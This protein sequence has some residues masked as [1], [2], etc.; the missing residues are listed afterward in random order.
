MRKSNTLFDNQDQPDSLVGLYL[1]RTL[2][3]I[4][5]GSC[6]F[7]KLFWW[8]VNI[9]TSEWMEWK[10]SASCVCCRKELLDRSLQWKCYLQYH[11]NL[12]KKLSKQISIP[13]AY[14]L[15]FDHHRSPTNWNCCDVFFVTMTSVTLC[16]SP[17]PHYLP[18]LP[19]CCFS[20]HCCSLPLQMFLLLRVLSSD[21]CHVHYHGCLSPHLVVLHIV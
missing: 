19:H 5:F 20:H 11:P 15:G 2:K 7:I 13:P 10:N 8:C 3:P 18:P 12:T 1:T 6:N 4:Y 9:T 16:R 14:T 17:H 21:R